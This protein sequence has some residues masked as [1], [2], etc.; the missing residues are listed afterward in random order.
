METCG[1]GTLK[2][3]F[4]VVCVAG[5]LTGGEFITAV[6]T[7]FHKT[8][9]TAIASSS[10]DVFLYCQEDG[11]SFIKVIPWSS[12]ENPKP[13]ALAF[14][15]TSEWLLIATENGSIF[16]VPIGKHLKTRNDSS[17]C[18]FSTNDLVIHQPCGSRAK[19][20]A[21]VWWNTLTSGASVAIIG[22]ELGELCFVELSSGKDVGGT[23]I[24]VPVKE[25]YLCRDNSGDTIYLLI[26]G[27][28]DRQWR[29]VLEQKSQHFMFP[30]ENISP[31]WMK[32]NL[33]FSSWLLQLLH[34]ARVDTCDID[35]EPSADSLIIT[36]HSDSG[37]TNLNTTQS[38]LQSTAAVPTTSSVSTTNITSSSANPSPSTS[39]PCESDISAPVSA[40]PERIH[41]FIYDIVAVPHYTNEKCLLA[42]IYKPNSCLM[43]YS[44]DLES[45]PL[46]V[47]KL[48][49]DTEQVILNEE[50][51]YALRKGPTPLITVVSTFYSASNKI[52]G[53]IDNKINPVLEDI[54]LPVGEEIV[55]VFSW[56]STSNDNFPSKMKCESKGKDEIHDCKRKY[57][58]RDDSVF[59]FEDNINLDSHTKPNACLVVT[60][61]SLFLCQTRKSVENLFMELTLG[62]NDI[63]AA[64]K[65]A[66]I[67]S[68]DSK[69][70]EIAGDYKLQR[71]SFASAIT[72]YKQS[73]CPHVKCSLKFAWSGFVPEFLTYMSSLTSGSGGPDLVVE[74][75]KH[76]ASLAVIAH[77]YQLSLPV[78]IRTLTQQQT[79]LKNLLLF[80]RNNLYYDEILT[81]VIAA[82]TWRWETLQYLASNRGLL[83]EKLHALLNLRN[84]PIITTPNAKENDAQKE[85]TSSI[86][87][88]REKGFLHCISDPELRGVLLVN[89]LLARSHMAFVLD[90]LDHLDVAT[91]RRLAALYDPTQAVIK[92]FL[93]SAYFHNPSAS[94]AQA[95][96]K[97]NQS[98]SL[99]PPAL[100]DPI[101][102]ETLTQ[103]FLA[104]LIK[105]NQKRGWKYNPDL[106][107]LKTIEPLK[108]EPFY[109]SDVKKRSLACGYGHSL[110]I[111]EGLVYSWGLGDYGCL[112]H[113][114]KSST[115]PSILDNLDSFIVS[116]FNKDI[117]ILEHDLDSRR[118]D[119]V[120]SRK[121]KKN[122]EL[123]NNPVGPELFCIKEKDC[124]V[125]TPEGSDGEC[126][127]P[128]VISYLTN[129]K[130][131]S[132]YGWGSSRYGQVGTGGTGRYPRPTL[133]S[134]FINVK[135][136]H[137]ACG[138]YHSLAVTKEGK[139]YT[140]GW[141]VHGQ[142]GH[143]NVEDCL[144][145][146]LVKNV[147]LTDKGHVY[148]W[149]CSTYGQVGTGG[150]TKITSPAKLN[151]P[152]K[153]TH[154]AAGYFH[155]IASTEDHKVYVW[156]SNPSSLRVQAQIQR[157]N[158]SMQQQQTNSETLSEDSSVNDKISENGG[159][160]PTESEDLKSEP[161]DE[162]NEITEFKEKECLDDNHLE[163]S[164]DIAGSSS[165]P[166]PPPS[167]PCQ[168]GYGGCHL[169]SANTVPSC[170][171]MEL[172]H[173][174]PKEVEMPHS[175]GAVKSLSAGSQ[176]SLLLTTHGAL[177]VW[178]RNISGQLDFNLAFDNHGQVWGWGSNYYNQLGQGI[179][180]G[181]E[182]PQGNKVFMLRTSKRV[183]KVPHSIHSN[184][185]TPRTIAHLPIII[186][187]SGGL[188]AHYKHSQEKANISI[189]TCVMLATKVRFITIINV[190]YNSFKL[191]RVGE[192]VR[193]MD[194]FLHLQTEESQS[195][196]R[197]VLQEGIGL[198]L[199]H[200]LP[201]PQLEE[202]LLTHLPR[203]VYPLALL[204][205][206][207]ESSVHGGEGI[208]KKL[209]E[210]E[211][212]YE[213]TA[214][215][216]S[217]LS[218]KFCLNLC[219]SVISHLQSGDY[220][221]EQLDALNQLAL[222][223]PGAG[224]TPKESSATAEAAEVMNIKDEVSVK[225][226]S[227]AI[228][229]SH[230]DVSTLKKMSEE[231]SGHQ[232]KGAKSKRDLS[233]SKSQQSQDKD[234]VL[235]TCGHHFT[236]KDFKE[237]VLPQLERTV[238]AVPGLLGKTA[239]VLLD[240]YHSDQPQMACPHCV[241]A[242]LTIKLTKHNQPS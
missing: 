184:V 205:F 41:K 212:V 178:G 233:R 112:G 193:I 189:E 9:I 74:Q 10:G 69:Y 50:I 166:P 21:V 71:R 122:K 177:F 31:E 15:P 36:P 232:E 29:L 73:H 44:P 237:T 120:F 235:F 107:T 58:E 206:G 139:L 46:Y 134:S 153:V 144:K 68:V 11:K 137:V 22:T 90:H 40:R 196:M 188:S 85:F 223:N 181:E 17:D 42:G 157:R 163:K 66:V 125:Q 32:R 207:E 182:K 67:F 104:I 169:V 208:P 229:L 98:S 55:N 103:M 63:D 56:P 201:I 173:L 89:P 75:R 167:K 5:G 228:N 126:Y 213:A 180:S 135:V 28:E 127:Q 114:P 154:L 116:E 61:K 39:I 57:S 48:P 2:G 95:H 159:I 108:R 38:T 190:T 241:L 84:S 80:I 129:M 215:I 192:A 204:L 99:L 211:T 133:I 146:M 132:V 100:D 220:N 203:T 70:F 79:S 123:S 150:I 138:Q 12:D 216:L 92:P 200:S 52:D 113:G 158:R 97:V 239:R 37:N 195:G 231:E 111:I 64:N 136:I 202:L 121:E 83:L 91:L 194:H 118:M 191:N 218:T 1:N 145:P 165:P 130:T 164:D 78:G 54:Y 224:V 77:L 24:T 14:D 23:Y 94:Y 60:K 162:S 59:E 86:C 140:W 124:L 33:V 128:K 8:S 234:S 72:L 141:G 51:I 13:S 49:E 102:M 3:I 19:P 199:T 179:N 26:T 109:D 20:T 225:S 174:L 7:S 160:K 186:N 35:K 214:R 236:N 53:E 175:Y 76:L 47:Y 143:G 151:F 156:G 87:R 142:L 238:T 147:A 34:Q 96:S 197:L 115:S 119:E 25:M 152:S 93:L 65:L 170:D 221:L 172:G 18:K 149:G 27:T 6:S 81:L 176:H 217:Q 105:L 16:I 106:L 117:Y 131:Y 226:T 210:E 209:S 187:R 171:P 168:K 240:Q 43:V 161:K 185:E 155:N 183:V 45:T 101:S 219:S 88:E 242:H 148:A 227:D 4:E 110:V 222:L 30:L 62:A 82:A 198:W 230:E